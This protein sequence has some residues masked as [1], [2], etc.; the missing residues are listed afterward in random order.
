MSTRDKGATDK[1][2]S[3]IN[4]HQ[5]RHGFPPTRVEIC[6]HMGWASTNSASYHISKLIKSGQITVKPMVARGIS[7]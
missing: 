4:K 7:L 2:L 6:K 1:V 5:K 3:F